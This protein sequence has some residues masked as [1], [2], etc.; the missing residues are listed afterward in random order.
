MFSRA[1]LANVPQ[2]P[3]A[4]L[5]REIQAAQR[6]LAGRRTFTKC[7]GSPPQQLPAM[8]PEPAKKRFATS[9]DK[10]RDQDALTKTR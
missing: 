6:L 3:Q 1:G 8:L 9:A 7:R 4:L 2:T 10:K 5:F